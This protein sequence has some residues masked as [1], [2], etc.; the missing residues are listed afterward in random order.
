[1]AAIATAQGKP[2]FPNPINP[3]RI[4][5]RKILKAQ[6]ITISKEFLYDYLTNK[7]ELKIA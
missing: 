7:N 4:P 1:L 6:T 2:S 3:I 5:E